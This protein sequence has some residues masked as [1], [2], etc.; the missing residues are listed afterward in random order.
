MK[1]LFILALMLIG[2]SSCKKQYS[3]TGELQEV[4]NKYPKSEVYVN[5]DEEDIFY[6]SDSTGLKM[7][8]CMS[9]SSNE[10][11]DVIPLTKVK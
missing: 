1:K 11:T 8:K 3:Q 10:I 7:I 5:I 9:T 2:F 4:L 6:V